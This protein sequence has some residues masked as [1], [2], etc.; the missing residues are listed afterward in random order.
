MASFKLQDVAGT[1]TFNLSLPEG[2]WCTIAR[3]R[4]RVVPVVEYPSFLSYQFERQMRGQILVAERNLGL[5]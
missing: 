1:S 4:T 5:S 3:K 2:P